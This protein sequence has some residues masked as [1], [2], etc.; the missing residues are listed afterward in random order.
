MMDG[1][2]R[3]LD[4]L[5]FSSCEGESFPLL[6]GDGVDGSLGLLA[7]VTREADLGGQAYTKQ[8]TSI[9]GR[10]DSNFVTYIKSL[11]KLFAEIS[12]FRCFLQ[13]HNLHQS[14]CREGCTVMMRVHKKGVPTQKPIQNRKIC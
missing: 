3:R 13:L 9:I 2:T 8:C 11:L 4:R 14:S 6:L 10:S 7:E 1:K 12:S 5:T